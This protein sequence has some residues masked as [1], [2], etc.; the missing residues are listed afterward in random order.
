MGLH[1]LRQHVIGY[2]VPEQFKDDPVA[3]LVLHRL[4]L[5]ANA[6]RLV[7]FL[8]YHLMNP[9]IYPYVVAK[10]RAEKAGGLRFTLSIS[11]SV[12]AAASASPRNLAP[13]AERFEGNTQP[14]CLALQ[15]FRRISK[16]RPLMGTSRRPS[17]VLLSGTK[18]TRFC[19]SRLSMRRKDI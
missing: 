12:W 19:Q 3:K 17:A 9:G 13:D 15:L 7:D 2:T 14:S 8:E 6:D 5:L 10:A 11:A 1:Y 16:T 18:I 4:Q